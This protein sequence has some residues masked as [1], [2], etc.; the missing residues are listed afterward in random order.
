MIVCI[1]QKH[2]YVSQ[3]QQ[4]HWMMPLKLN[5][6]AACCSSYWC[7][8]FHVNFVV[9][10]SQTIFCLNLTFLV[11]EPN[12]TEPYCFGK[13]DIFGSHWQFPHVTRSFNAPVSQQIDRSCPC[14]ILLQVLASCQQYILTG[15]RCNL[16]ILASNLNTAATLAPCILSLLFNKP[17][18]SN[19][20]PKH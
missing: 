7:L 16:H 5:V 2:K 12:Q 18:C 20:H 19:C 3:A 4:N 1:G 17:Y 14:W 15:V 13:G 6:Q 8:L 9:T 10:F 11:P